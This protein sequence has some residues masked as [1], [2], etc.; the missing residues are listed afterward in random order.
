MS[1]FANLE[2]PQLSEA[3]VTLRWQLEARMA[4][5]GIQPPGTAET[6]RLLTAFLL[7][8]DKAAR[9]YVAGRAHLLQHQQEGSIKSFVV[10][11]GEF[12]TCI[13]SIKR[14]LRLQIVLGTRLDAPQQN[15]T[16]RK[17]ASSFAR[18]VKGVRDAI[19]H[20]DQDILSPVGIAAGHPHILR[21]S[22][23]GSHL[24]I[25]ARRISFNAVHSVIGALHR[26]G[27]TMIKNLPSPSSAF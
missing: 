11:C 2:A 6:T 1:L 26:A 13:N 16:D 27:D 22:D 24:E 4:Y 20:I 14:A 18:L 8:V 23:D 9:E 17:L 10:G 7:V 21:V 15:R 19:E 3:D 12:E 5:H 25:G